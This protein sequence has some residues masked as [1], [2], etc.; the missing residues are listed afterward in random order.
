MV[1]NAP[2]LDQRDPDDTLR[3]S[4]SAQRAVIRQA[5]DQRG[6]FSYALALDPHQGE[7]HTDQV[8]LCVSGVPGCERDFRHLAPYLAQR[9][10]VARL[11]M[12]GFG[13]LI[14]EAPL[15]DCGSRAEYIRRVIKAEGWT[16]VGLIGHSMG[17]P[18]ALL[19]ARALPELSSLTLI[20]SV[21]LRPHR[22]MRFGGGTARFI[23]ALMSLPLLGAWLEQRGRALMRRAGFRNHPLDRAQL[24][25][26][27][28]HIWGLKFV[29]LRA[30][31]PQLPPSLEVLCV[32]AQDDHIVEAEV[33]E[34]LAHALS[35]R[36]AQSRTHVFEEGGHN[37]QKRHAA[38]L[39]TLIAAVSEGERR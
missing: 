17:G 39:A 13:A 25:L 3:L 29:T 23:Y 20:C 12:P 11:I 26:I 35:A 32:Y 8:W 22:A 2:T 9:G 28:A 36:G 31:I 5:E 38:A 1:N 33:S 4:P 34:E 16:R 30:A 27:L 18:A 14:D 6:S 10:S 19:A 37:P 15:S 24:K 7:A 21:G